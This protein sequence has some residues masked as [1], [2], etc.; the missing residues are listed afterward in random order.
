MGP[1]ILCLLCGVLLGAVFAYGLLA[2]SPKDPE[3]KGG[4]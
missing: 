4:A 2:N 1:C 3:D